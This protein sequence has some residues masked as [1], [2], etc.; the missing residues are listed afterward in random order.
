MVKVIICLV[1]LALLIT[2][3]APTSP[4][5]SSTHARCQFGIDSAKQAAKAVLELSHKLF[6]KLSKPEENLV[7]SPVSIALALALVESGANGA[8]RNELQA[9]L[10]PPG[11]NEAD[12]SKLYESLQHQL[13]IKGEKTS[14]S[15]AN[16]MFHAESINLK[17]EFAN[18]TKQCFET[19]VDK[20][21]FNDVEAAR[22]QINQWV[23]EKTAQK[24]PE[25]FKSGSLAPTTVAL[26]ANA[27]YLKAAWADRFE[28][29]EDLPFYKFGRDDQ[30]Q[31]VPFVVQERKYLHAENDK[32]QVIEIPYEG[33]SSLAFYVFLPKQRAGFQAA[34]NIDKEQLK[35]LFSTFSQKKVNLKLPKFSFR[36]S[37]DL[38]QVLQQIGVNK[39]F[40][41][42]SDLSRI[43]DR[44]I[45]IDKAVHEAYIKVNENGTEAAAATGFSIVPMMA[46]LPSQPINFIADHPFFFTIAHKPTKTLLFAG[47]VVK[48]EQ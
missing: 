44:A 13:Q 4:T 35:T 26:L 33:A 21:P 8:T 12:S 32:I 45:K 16:G 11:S 29:S 34:E 1:L 15:V 38:M 39:I 47:K 2:P 24:I 37:I 31:T 20:A 30:A 10:S 17:P 27:V 43:A 9:H 14:F 22:R 3:I 36:S 23:S 40:T 19:Q 6:K 25:L 42:E 28:R 5:A 7:F 18:R 48:I 41:E 46:E